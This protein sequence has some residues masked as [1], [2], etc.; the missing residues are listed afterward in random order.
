MTLT[1][2]RTTAPGQASSI[3]QI[4]AWLLLLLSVFSL[5]MGLAMIGGVAWLRQ[6]DLPAELT[7]LVVA[8]V[9]LLGWL[10]EHALGL[11]CLLVV[12]CLPCVAVS[13]GMLRR[14][15]WARVGFI[16]LLLATAIGNLALVPLLDRV[17][18]DLS[19]AMF[20]DLSAADLDGLMQQMRRARVQLGMTTA[21]SCLG[22]GAVHVWLAW[23]FARADMRALYSC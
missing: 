17:L 14:I 7:G 2:S 20:Q 16:V 22:V 9:G 3:N 18:V 13:I 11:S 10:W 6:A 8:P 4:S 21:A 15:G 19:H 23:R 1:S 5:G 12:S